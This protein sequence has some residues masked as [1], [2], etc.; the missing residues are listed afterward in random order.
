MDLD[1]IE[2]D[3]DHSKIADV[4][5]SHV[6]QLLNQLVHL[7]KILY[8]GDYIEGDF[9]SIFFNLLASITA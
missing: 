8:G 3:V 5:T 6:V 2:G 7:D 4:W 9:D 1:D